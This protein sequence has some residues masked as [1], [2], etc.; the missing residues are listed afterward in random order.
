[1]AIVNNSQM[2]MLNL[3]LIATAAGM[4]SAKDS[5]VTGVG[6]QA[7]AID[8]SGAVTNVT[9]DVVGQQSA[10]PPQPKIDAIKSV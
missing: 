7:R 2:I 6:A 10:I 9:G 3:G 1:M 5:S 4:L 8:S